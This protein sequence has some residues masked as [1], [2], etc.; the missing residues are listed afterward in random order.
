MNLLFINL[1]LFCTDKDNI[2]MFCQYE[3]FMNKFL[4]CI[5]MSFEKEF[6]IEKIF[7]VQNKI[8]EEEYISYSYKH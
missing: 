6:K 4:T 1:K 8:P 5:C 2:F 7:E 3:V